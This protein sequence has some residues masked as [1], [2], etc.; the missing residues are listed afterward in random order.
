MKEPKDLKAGVIGLGM[1]GGG[2]A[3]SLVK[4]NRTPAIYD[5]IPDTAKKHKLLSGQLATPAEVAA[6]SDIIM[7][8]VFNYEQCKEVIIGENGLLKNAH[9]DMVFVILSTISIEEI[10]ELHAICKAKE[11]NLLDCGVTPGTLA[12]QNG[13]IAMV[14]GD[15]EVFDYAKPILDDW[16]GESIYCGPSGAG[17]A[18]KIARNINTYGIWRVTAEAFRLA[19]A[20]GADPATYLQVLETADKVDNLFYKMLHVRASMPD[21]RLPESMSRVAEYMEKDLKASRQLSDSL[22]LSLPTRDNL[23]KYCCDTFDAV[24][25]E[26]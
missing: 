3:V 1:I 17:M 18:C 10:K 7:I 15:R 6:V 12:D 13:L 25:T 9:K 14:G 21:Y 16:S 24:E 11:V 2:V 23:M 5:V 26:S 22:G 4:K 20:A 19:L 8:A